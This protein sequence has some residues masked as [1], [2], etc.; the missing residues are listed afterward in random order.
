VVVVA[1]PR[2]E[3]MM[4]LLL[5]LLLLLCVDTDDDDDDNDGITLSSETWRSRDDE[6]IQN[7]NGGQLLLNG[8]YRVSELVR[9]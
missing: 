9:G 2:R 1:V 6:M 8:L 5:L 4:L 7:K 3:A